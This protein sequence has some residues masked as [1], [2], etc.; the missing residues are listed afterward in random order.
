MEEGN[1]LVSEDPLEILPEEI[2]LPILSFLTIKELATCCLV[3][4]NWKR[5][6]EDNSLWLELCRNRYKRRNIF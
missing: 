1:V 5:F 4:K 2:V 3:C 6:A